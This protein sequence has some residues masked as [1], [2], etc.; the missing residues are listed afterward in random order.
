MAA[1]AGAG[2]LAFGLGAVTSAIVGKPSPQGRLETRNGISVIVESD[3]AK[4]WISK[5]TDNVIII[6]LPQNLITI[7][8]FPTIA[9]DDLR[10]RD[11]QI[12]RTCEELQQAKESFDAAAKAFQDASAQLSNATQPDR[13][14]S[15]ATQ[16]V[17]VTTGTFVKKPMTTTPAA[18]PRNETTV[19]AYKPSL[20]VDQ[21]RQEQDE[22]QKAFAEAAQRW[23]NLK[24][25]QPC[26]SRQ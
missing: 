16:S 17:G 18:V 14:S 12:G 21:K 13:A 23:L 7:T 6:D 11:P 22:A 26:V 15:G 2:V 24:S 4:V 20:D 5:K 19:E 8:G 9:V 25:N 1:Y 10:P 3:A